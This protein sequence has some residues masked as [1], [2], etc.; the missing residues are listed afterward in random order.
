L[1]AFV[2]RLAPGRWREIRPPTA[3]ELKATT[4]LRLRLD[5]ASAKARS[6]PSVEDEADYAHP[7]WAGVLPL[8]V[9]AGPLQPDP[10]LRSGTATPAYLGAFKLG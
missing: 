4:V 2:E 5:E 8:A 1:Q 10:R 3:T 9:Q 7:C 6:G